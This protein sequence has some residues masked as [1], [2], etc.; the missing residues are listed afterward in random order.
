MLAGAEC[1]AGLCPQLLVGHLVERDPLNTY[2]QTT[3]VADY[4]LGNQ[5]Y[6]I[7]R[8]IQSSLW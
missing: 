6:G 2:T 4:V 3:K 8:D 7:Q 1:C 5:I